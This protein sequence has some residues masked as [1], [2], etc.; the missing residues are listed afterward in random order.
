MSLSARLVPYSSVEV[1]AEGLFATTDRPWLELVFAGRAPSG[2]WV[3][4][5]Y[6]ASYLDDLVR[7]L[8]AFETP[9]GDEWDVMR[10]GL[11]GRAC[12]MSASLMPWPWHPSLRPPAQ[13]PKGHTRAAWVMGCEL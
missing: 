9:S 6:R 13:V 10:A 12:W 11:C 7:P 4:I 3:R 2:C 1:T 8:I 5:S